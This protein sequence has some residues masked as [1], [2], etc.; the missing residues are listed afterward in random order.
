MIRTSCQRPFF[1]MTTSPGLTILRAASSSAALDAGMGR[2][3]RFPARQ[4]QANQQAAPVAK[5]DIGRCILLVAKVLRL[6]SERL[7]P[8]GR[9]PVNASTGPDAG[10]MT[11]W[12]TAGPLDSRPKDRVLPARGNADG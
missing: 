1:R 12:I 10:Q 7:A 3:K 6:L 4:M 11:L 9:L 5:K 2:A 8:C